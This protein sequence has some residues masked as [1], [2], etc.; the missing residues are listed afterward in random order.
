MRAPRR[1]PGPTSWAAAAEAFLLVTDFTV[2]TRRQYRAQ[3]RYASKYLSRVPL[4][5][6]TV[7]DLEA[8]RAAVLDGSRGAKTQALAV[9]R[10]FLT[11]AEAHALV[12]LRPAVIRE[13]LRP[14]GAARGIQPVGRATRWSRGR[15]GAAPAA[16]AAAAR[17][18]RSAP[19]TLPAFGYPSGVAGLA[20]AAEEIH[21]LREALLAADPARWGKLVRRMDHPVT[22]RP[23][24]ATAAALN[25]LR[26]APDASSDARETFLAGLG[27]EGPAGERRLLGALRELR[28]A[29]AEQQRGTLGRTVW[30]L[31]WMELPIPGLQGG[32]AKTALPS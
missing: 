15:R 20:L 28:A 10:V 9:A 5:Q 19:A 14:L 3:L 2:S 16:P 11:W 17:A 27:Y 18:A 1:S 13:A 8:Y 12:Q 24:G 26:A 29:F 30:Q 25:A 21:A 23:G 7:E 31:H 6:L 32:E 22:R 4:A